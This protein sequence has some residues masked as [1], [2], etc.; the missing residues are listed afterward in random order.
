MERGSQRRQGDLEAHRSA[1]LRATRLG[2]GKT[3][4]FSTSASASAFFPS[5]ESPPLPLRPNPARTHKSRTPHVDVYRPSFNPETPSNTQ[6]HDGFMVGT[7][8]PA[9]LIFL[10]CCASAFKNRTKA[11]RQHTR[12]WAADTAASSARFVRQVSSGRSAQHARSNCVADIGVAPH[13]SRLMLCTT[14]HTPHAPLPRRDA[15]NA[16]WPRL[17]E[18][19]EPTNTGAAAAPAVELQG[20]RV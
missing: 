7:T 3:G 17:A 2:C 12:R 10:C 5:P 15:V 6:D 13:G 4:D 14:P 11:Q 18:A 9:I 8:L 1:D 20:S 16:L 19:S